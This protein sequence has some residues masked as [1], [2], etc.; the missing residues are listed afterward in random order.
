MK[1]AA[2]SNKF[3]SPNIAAPFDATRPV[4]GPGTSLTDGAAT[5]PNDGFFD[6]SATYMGAFKDASDTWATTGKWVVWADN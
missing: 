5:P 4:F 1:G 6:T 3:T 2:L